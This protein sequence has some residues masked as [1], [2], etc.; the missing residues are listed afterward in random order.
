VNE[1]V[2]K[3]KQEQSVNPDGKGDQSSDSN[4][5]QSEEIEVHSK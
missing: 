2:E 5:E 3:E 1:H 4:I